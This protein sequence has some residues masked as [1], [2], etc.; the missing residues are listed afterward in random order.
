MNSK[1]LNKIILIASMLMLFIVS[2][3]RLESLGEHFTQIDEAGVAELLLFPRDLTNI[4]K[5]FLKKRIEEQSSLIFKVYNHA[6]EKGY[7]DNVL[8]LG[9]SFYQFFV[10]PI[11]QTF[12]PIQFIG[13]KLL[14]SEDQSYREI[15]FWARFPSFLFSVSALVLIFTFYQNIQSKERLPF[16]LLAI[17]LMGLSLENIIFAQQAISYSIGVFVAM[18]L[19]LLYLKYSQM[20]QWSKKDII[21]LGFFLAILVN[22]QYQ[23]LFF[24]PAFFLTLLVSQS[25][26]Y[27]LCKE[28]LLM[29][30]LAGIVFSILFLPTYIIFLWRHRNAGLNYNSGPNGEFA[31]SIPISEGLMVKVTYFFEFFIYNWISIFQSM[32][33]FVP[34]KSILYLPSFLFLSFLFIIGVISFFQ[35]SNPLKQISIFFFFSFLTWSALA[36]SGKIALSPTRHS[37]ILLPIFVIIICEGCFYFCYLIQPN[38]TKKINLFY[39]VPC[40]ASLMV[41]VL[42]FSSY[43]DEKESRKDVFSESEIN[44]IIN[45]HNV[46]S[47][48]LYGCSYNLV[49][50]KKINKE[51]PIFYGCAN[52]RK[53]NH[54]AQKHNNIFNKIAFVSGGGLLNGKKFELLVKSANAG[55]KEEFSDYEVK[56]SLIKPAGTHM[57]YSKKVDSQLNGLSLIIYEKIRQ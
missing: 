13:T 12:A 29:M 51:Y 39:L 55:E 23:V 7:V 40:L 2:F 28:K 33:S 35:K 41:S 47:I 56:Y 50:M 57:E 37:L 21:K 6:D 31:F 44:K 30:I 24:L 32:T 22:C 25:R 19:I 53:S 49:L 52:Y 38:L 42:F 27:F 10:V 45:D 11:T 8:S 15:L 4:N 18:L 1:S 3:I 5:A 48:I 26:K 54:Y 14:I 36:I 34:E 20:K 17:T 46:D 16:R 9:N 43:P